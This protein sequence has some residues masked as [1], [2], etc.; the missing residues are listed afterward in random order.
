MTILYA[1]DD[2]DDREL[3]SEVFSKIDPSISCV[4][5]RDGREAIKTLH[6]AVELPDYIF[7]D[8][9]MPLMGGKDCLIELKKDKRLRVIPVIIYSTTIDRDE[10]DYFYDLGASSFLR[11]PNSFE[12]LCSRLSMFI[13]LCRLDNDKRKLTA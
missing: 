7:L 4:T 13:K 11:K 1:D 6:L 3:V 10:I 12:E 2:P 8:I 9:N 5:V